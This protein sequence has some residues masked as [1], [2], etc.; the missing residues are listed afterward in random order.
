M[1][2]RAKITDFVARRRAMRELNAMDARLLNDLG[3]ERADIAM[4]VRGR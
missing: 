3:I 1:T 4:A 2:I